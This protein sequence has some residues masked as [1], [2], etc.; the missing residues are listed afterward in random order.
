MAKSMTHQFL[1]QADA[2]ID[3][4]A[5]MVGTVTIGK[6]ETPFQGAQHSRVPPP[7]EP[8]TPP[9]ATPTPY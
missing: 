9:N 1:E 4:I 5:D 6:V 8:S 3:G 2:T 7:V